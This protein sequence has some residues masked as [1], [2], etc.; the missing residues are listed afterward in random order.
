M[1]NPEWDKRIA[2]AEELTR[3]YPF[4]SEL[5]NFYGQV[6][7]L[8]RELY[9]HAASAPVRSTGYRSIREQLDL[10]LAAQQLPAL[11]LLV[12]RHGPPGLAQAAREL[13]QKTPDQWMDLLVAYARGDEE[14]G[15]PAEFFARACLQPYAEYCVRTSDIQLTD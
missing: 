3:E 7:A 8:Q 14:R 2:R 13:G 1:K 15:T 6:A 4:A 12:E 11:I 10:A 5:L 9:D